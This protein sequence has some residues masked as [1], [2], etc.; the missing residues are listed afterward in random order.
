M[1]CEAMERRQLLKVLFTILW[2]PSLAEAG[3]LD[4]FRKK[5]ALPPEGRFTPV[6]DLYVVDIKGVPGAAR[7]VAEDP[8]SFRLRVHGRVARELVLTLEEIRGLP[9]VRRDLIL[10]CVDNPRGTRVGRLRVEGVRL[11]HLLE[12]AGTGRDSVDVVLRAMDGYHTSVEMG[13]VTKGDPLL[14]YAIN[15]D[16][17]GRLLRDL[18]LDHGYPMRVMCPGKWGYKSPKWLHE[19]EVVDYDYR[20]YWEKRGWSDRGRYRVDYLEE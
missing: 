3:I 19:I 11:S 16:R 4:L 13:Y 1:G 2:M 12:M 10:E 5:D 14:V 6:K 20:G 15:H 8:S 17:D 7:Q 9:S 18:P